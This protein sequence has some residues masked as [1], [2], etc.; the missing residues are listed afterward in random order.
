MDG[1]LLLIPPLRR[2]H[3]SVIIGA[4]SPLQFRREWILD[5]TFSDGVL[6]LF[7]WSLLRL[8]FRYNT[9]LGEQR[10]QALRAEAAARDAQLRML[11]CQLN[12]HFLFNTL[13]SIRALINEDRGRAREIVTALS[14]YLAIEPVRVTGPV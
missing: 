13:N 11:A 10:E 12:P 9:A 7:G 3:R 2:R 14:G 5:G 6:P 8:G 1:R 4:P